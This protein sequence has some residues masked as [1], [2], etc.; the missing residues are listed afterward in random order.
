MNAMKYRTLGRTGLRVSEIGFGALEIGRSWGM[1]AGGTANPPTE[2]EAISVIHKAIDLG[3]TFF[4]TAPAYQ[5]SEERL[6]KA[7]VGK[8]D[9]IVLATKCGEWFDVS[10][11]YDYSTK[12]TEKFVEK[13]LINLRTNVLDLVQIHSGT[14]DVVR[15]NEA[16]EGLR[17]ARDAGKIRYIGISVDDNETA[18][19]AIK[20]GGFDTVQPSYH[21]LRRG[22]EPEVLP[23]AMKNNIGIIIKDPVYRGRLTSKYVYLEE[24]AEKSVITQLDTTARSYGMTLTQLAL[25]FILTHDAVSTIIAGTKRAEHLEENVQASDGKKMEETLHRRIR[26]LLHTIP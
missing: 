1:A 26:E 15:N 22:I 5:M 14:L 12:G 20:H 25:R 23:L 13:S 7:L 19:A 17:K 11:V 24:S 21:M 6:G 2:Q 9:K 10:S 4:D 16:Y 8:R 3:I 18:I